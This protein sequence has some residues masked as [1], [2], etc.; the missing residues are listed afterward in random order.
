MLQ[1]FLQPLATL[2]LSKLATAFYANQKHNKTKSDQTY[3]SKSIKAL[4]FPLQ[5]LPEVE[6]S[7]GF[8][9]LRND[10]TIDLKN[11]R[12]SIM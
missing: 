3:V 12:M 4:G 7:K 5:G 10:F 11:F 1:P 9:A 2:V 8:K 6:Q